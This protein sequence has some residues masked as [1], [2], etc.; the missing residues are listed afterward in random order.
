VN[1]LSK[2]ERRVSIHNFSEQG[3]QYFTGLL[4]P[5]DLVPQRPELKRIVCGYDGFFFL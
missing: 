3:K 5:R 2:R 4:Q 1:S